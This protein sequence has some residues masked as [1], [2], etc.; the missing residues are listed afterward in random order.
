VPARW[1][2][3]SLTPL[4]PHMGV[5]TRR[6]HR[7]RGRAGCGRE[8]EDPGAGPTAPTLPTQP[9][10]VERRSH[11]HDHVRH[12]TTALFVALEIATG[13]VT[14][15]GKPGHT[16]AMSSRRRG[17]GENTTTVGL[18]WRSARRCRPLRPGWRSWSTTSRRSSGPAAASGRSAPPGPSRRPPR[19]RRH[20]QPWRPE[21]RLSCCWSAWWSGADHGPC[22]PTGPAE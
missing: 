16:S 22:L 9:G 19:N 17:L 12:G 13:Q 8:D 2:T 4:A 18:H 14:E 3:R 1:P 6:G 11:D 20:E 10:P 15:E 7:Q 5:R 21:D